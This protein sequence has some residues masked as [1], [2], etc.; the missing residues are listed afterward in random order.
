MPTRRLVLSLATLLMLLALPMLRGCAPA[1]HDAISLP[2]IVA[3]RGASHL[4]PENTL[5]AFSLA[6]ELEA[7][8]VEGDFYLTNDGAIVC[9]HDETTERTAGVDR[10]VESQRLDE[11]RQLDVGRWKG[12]AWAGERIPTLTEVLDTVPD[13]RSILIEVKSD[14]RIVPT[15]LDTMIASGLDLDQMIVICFDEDVI[16]AVERLRPDVRT[17]WLASFD[18]DVLGRWTPTL[19]QLLDT[20]R[21]TGTDGLDLKA[22]FSVIDAA[23]VTRVHAAGLELHTWTV[24]TTRDARRLAELDVDSITTNRPGWLRR[25]FAG[26]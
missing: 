24:N 20:A 6:W 4:A 19:A 10:S 18:A 15:L 9:H 22:N 17:L 12:A 13:G 5:A 11:L 26:H 14:A 8:L 21:R 16:E 2:L 3:H 7:D 23:F 25:Q 1:R